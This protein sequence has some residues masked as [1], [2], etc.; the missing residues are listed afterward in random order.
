MSPQYKIRRVVHQFVRRYLKATSANASHGHIR[1]AAGPFAALDESR[2]LGNRQAIPSSE[3][4]VR[5]G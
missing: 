3:S 2:R 1:L 4:G 5:H